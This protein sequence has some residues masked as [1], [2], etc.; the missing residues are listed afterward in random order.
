MK[1]KAFLTSKFQPPGEEVFDKSQ[2][3]AL[4]R[5]G[6]DSDSVRSNHVHSCDD[7]LRFLDPGFKGRENTG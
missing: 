6:L 7:P 5:S 3:I 2:S 4:G 1:I